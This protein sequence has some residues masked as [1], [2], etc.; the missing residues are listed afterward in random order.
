[1]IPSILE[2]KVLRC[3]IWDQKK[4][5][6]IKQ[7][8][9]NI[10]STL[11]RFIGQHLI[12]DTVRNLRAL[13]RLPKLS[14]LQ[15]EESKAFMR[16]LREHGFTNA[17]ISVIVDEKWKE[18]TIKRYTRGVKTV[19]TD[20][21]DKLLRLLSDFSSVGGTLQDLEDFSSYK[22]T[23]DSLEVNYVT[24]LT[25]I[26]DIMHRGYLIED[27][28]YIK[29]SLVKS[30]LTIDDFLKQ[31]TITE[32]LNRQGIFDQELTIL[33][34]MARVYGGINGIY[35][36]LE[37]YGDIETIKNAE[38]QAQVSLNVLQTNFTKLEKKY[39]TLKPFVDFAEILIMQYS[40]NHESLDILVKVAEKYGGLTNVLEAI[41]EY[42]NIHEL[43]LEKVKEIKIGRNLKTLND[44][45]S[46]ELLNVSEKV[47]EMHQDIGEINANYAR[48]LRLQKIHELLTKPRDAEIDSEEFL[49]IVSA[50]LS[51]IIEYGN[52][53][54]ESVA[55]WNKFDQRLEYARVSIN[56]ILLGS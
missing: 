4:A 8:D 30:D 42:G 7:A 12:V 50:L 38:I 37:K 45:Y 48:S 33:I 22:K 5:I 52:K 32:D 19:S 6:C 21:R 44:D 56:N 53:N 43:R 17:D 28:I 36:A 55:G 15:R 18:P 54:K 41:T 16:E 27:L 14:R 29:D 20:E 1:M 47:K 51:G 13:A 46:L 23:L 35:T 31:V 49:R 40:F 25:L 26:R 9:F 39:A 10:N 2:V 11:P 3:Y 34:N 24:I